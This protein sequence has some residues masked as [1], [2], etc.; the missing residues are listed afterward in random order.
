MLSVLVYLNHRAVLLVLAFDSED[1][2]DAYGKTDF[3]VNQFVMERYRGIV[4]S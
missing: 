4:R 1:I 2:Q 3:F